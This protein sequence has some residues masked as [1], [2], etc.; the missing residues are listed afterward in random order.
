MNPQKARLLNVMVH[1]PEC[2]CAMAQK[3]DY[4]VYCLNSLCKQYQILY[5]PPTIPL[6]PVSKE[7]ERT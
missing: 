7:K 3:P 4:T 6:N 5:E 1:C 2:E